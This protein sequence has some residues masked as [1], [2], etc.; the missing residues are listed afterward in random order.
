MAAFVLLLYSTPTEEKRET[1]GEQLEEDA[2]NVEKSYS[3]CGNTRSMA[4]MVYFAENAHG[5]DH[6]IDEYKKTQS[7]D[8]R[9]P[10]FDGSES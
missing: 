5:V 7:Q 10:H 8:A 2:L 3:A 6:M 1:Q 4:L 9:I